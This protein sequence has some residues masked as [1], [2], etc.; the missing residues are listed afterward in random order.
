MRS[1]TNNLRNE[2]NLYI[3]IDDQKKNL[4]ETTNLCL[5]ED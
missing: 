4:N 1:K 5:L 2:T 3:L